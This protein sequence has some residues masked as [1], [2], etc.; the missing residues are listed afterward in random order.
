MQPKRRGSNLERRGLYL[1]DLFIRPESCGKGYGRRLLVE[2]ARIA[3]DRDCGRVEWS[4]L[5]W[6]ELAKTSYRKVGGRPMGEWTVWRISG[7]NLV[8]LAE[9]DPV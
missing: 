6:N 9:T 3:V 4:V 2:L 5:D 8:R 7:A 1:E